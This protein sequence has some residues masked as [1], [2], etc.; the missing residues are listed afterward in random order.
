MAA[1]KEDD[2]FKKPFDVAAS[3]RSEASRKQEGS[4]QPTES[5][6]KVKSK[7]SAS[8]GSSKETINEEQE[9]ERKKL[10]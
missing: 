2:V 4:N 8:G 6:Q 9:V 5:P 10:Q 1:K 7:P 3:S